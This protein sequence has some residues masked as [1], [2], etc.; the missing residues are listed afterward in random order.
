LRERSTEEL[1]G[2]QAAYDGALAYLDAEVGRLL[3]DL[4][5]RGVLR[6]TL[7]IIT[8]D[9]GE[10][11]G[12]HGHTGHG[13]S[14]YTPVIHVPLVVLPPGDA[15]AAARVARYVS[16]RDV[17]ATIEQAARP[18]SRVMPG[19][20]LDAL[21]RGD[22]LAGVSPAFSEVDRLATLPPRYPVAAAGLRSLIVEDRWHFIRS[23]AGAEE[24]YD[25]SADFLERVNLV[26]RPEHAT[27]VAMMRDSLAVLA[28]DAPR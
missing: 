27:R 2:L 10:E 20:S 1:Q 8:S 23:Q 12:E 24:L 16:L 6:N 9:H 4:E 14:L 28:G 26:T 21:W 18:A 17:A 15:R 13:S 5:R 22:S 7:V 25:L 11:F 19:T 3:D